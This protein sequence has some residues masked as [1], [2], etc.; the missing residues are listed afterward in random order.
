MYLVSVGIPKMRA[1]PANDKGRIAADR[2]EGA[3]RR[4]DA[5]G[6]H[7]FG[8]FLQFARSFDL[9]AHGCNHCETHKYSSEMKPVWR[10]TSHPKFTGYSFVRNIPATCAHYLDFSDMLF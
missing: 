10:A 1:L 3:H 8:A 9:A 4:I 7:L 5:A 2:P 6:N